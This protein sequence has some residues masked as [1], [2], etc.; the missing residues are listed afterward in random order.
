MAPATPPS[1]HSVPSLPSRFRMPAPS[2]AAPPSTTA[3]IPAAVSD[4][5]SNNDEITTNASDEPAI[6]PPQPSSSAE[7]DAPVIAPKQNSTKQPP[8][9]PLVLDSMPAS[10]PSN[11]AY[12]DLDERETSAL[13]TMLSYMQSAGYRLAPGLIE[14]YANNILE[15]R[16]TAAPAAAASQAPAKATTKG[17]P[18]L[19]AATEDA[20]EPLSSLPSP[21]SPPP[22][23]LEAPPRRKIKP[24]YIANLIQ[25]HPLYFHSPPASPTTSQAPEENAASKSAPAAAS[26][27]DASGAVDEET[28]SH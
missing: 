1:F 28:Q 14:D 17:E 13:L 23:L 26:E 20:A 18:V 25:L 7:T 27:G 24:S 21:L 11:T 22:P 16:A 19:P 15:N 12:V 9:P 5:S 2:P 10:A 6:T 8:P 4:D 3:P